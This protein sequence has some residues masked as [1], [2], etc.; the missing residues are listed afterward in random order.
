MTENWRTKMERSFAG[1][2]L[3][4]A[5]GPPFFFSAMEAMVT[6]SLRRPAVTSSALAPTRSPE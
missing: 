2:D 4:V 1:T 6:P 3:P 5:L